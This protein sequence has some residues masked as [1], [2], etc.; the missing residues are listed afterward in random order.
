L[1]YYLPKQEVVKILEEVARRFEHSQLVMDTAP[2]SY[3]RGLMKWL[4]NLESRAWG[5]DVSFASGMKNSREIE[6]FASG[7]KVIGE[8]KGNVGPIIIVTV[9]T[10]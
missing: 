6:S 8:A 7:F 10:S 2:E 3:S 1:F 5:V 9:N 4:I